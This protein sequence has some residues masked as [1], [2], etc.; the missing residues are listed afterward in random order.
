MLNRIVPGSSV[1]VYLNSIDRNEFISIKLVKHVVT[2][3]QTCSL[4]DFTIYQNNLQAALIVH[5]T[6][7]I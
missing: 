1:K 5:L 2:F 7:L 3:L 4:K 6:N